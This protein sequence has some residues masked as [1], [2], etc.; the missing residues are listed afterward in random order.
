MHSA[1]LSE[2]PTSSTF[3]QSHSLHLSTTLHTRIPEDSNLHRHCHEK[4][5]L[6]VEER[7]SFL[8]AVRYIEV[9]FIRTLLDSQNGRVCYVFQWNVKISDF[10]QLSVPPVKYFDFRRFRKIA[11][12]F[13]MSVLLFAW[14]NLAPTVRIFIEI[15]IWVLFENLSRKFKVR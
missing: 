4:L 2:E 8:K 3:R 10:L 15:Y 11:T 6:L 9:T 5:T 7:R 14:N 13:V 12:S 1:I